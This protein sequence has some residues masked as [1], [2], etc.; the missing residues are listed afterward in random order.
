MWVSLSFSLLSL[1]RRRANVILVTGKFDGGMCVSICRRKREREKLDKPHAYTCIMRKEGRK[2]KS[3]AWVGSMSRSIA[4][5]HS[6]SHWY[7][8]VKGQGLSPSSLSLYFLLLLSLSLSPSSRLHLI[9]CPFLS[10]SFSSFIMRIA[11]DSLESRTTCVHLHHFISP[12]KVVCL[13]LF[14]YQVTGTL[15]LSPQ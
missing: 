12:C 9:S 7:T 3:F 8:R 6:Y 5:P 11:V 14:L 13:C 15:Y 4:P 10:D 1:V 2:R